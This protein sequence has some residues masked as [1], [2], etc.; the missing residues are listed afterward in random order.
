MAGKPGKNEASFFVDYETWVK[1]S[2]LWLLQ[3][4]PISPQ[5]PAAASLSIREP[6]KA[7]YDKD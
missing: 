2:W 1:N 5:S 4:V 6:E 3:P 7:F